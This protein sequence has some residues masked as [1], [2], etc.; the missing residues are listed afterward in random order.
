MDKT[1]FLLAYLLTLIVCLGLTIGLI[2]LISKG[3]KQYFVNLTQDTDIA[4]FFVKLTNIILLLAGFG[5]ALKGL[6]DTSST[7]NWLTLT[8]DVASQLKN[9]FTNLFIAL[10]AFAIAFFILHIAAKRTTK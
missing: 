8:W 9:S 10:I 6:Y 7:A 2:I 5:A 3:L 1:T 4:K